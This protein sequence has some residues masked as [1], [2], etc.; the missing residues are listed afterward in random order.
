MTKSWK[1]RGKVAITGKGKGKKVTNSEP[2]K[3]KPKPIHHIHAKRFLEVLDSVPW[4]PITLSAKTK[5]AMELVL[6]WQ[7]VASDDKVII[8]YQWIP[9][10]EILGPG[11]VPAG[12]QFC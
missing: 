2:D 3:K 12:H 1:L 5:R 9:T 11:L 7:K 10:L 6:E 8:F 4:V